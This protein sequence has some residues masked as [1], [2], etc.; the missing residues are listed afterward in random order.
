MDRDL[1]PDSDMKNISQLLLYTSHS[2][3]EG[4]NK[5]RL[6]LNFNLLRG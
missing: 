3:D 5:S 6:C 4:N 1:L 2:E